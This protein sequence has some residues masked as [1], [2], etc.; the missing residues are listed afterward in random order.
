MKD[1]L[2]NLLTVLALLAAGLVLLVCVSIFVNP[3]GMLNPLPPPTMPAPLILPTATATSP[4]LPPTWTATPPLQPGSVVATLKPSSTPMPRKSQFV[5]PTF[6]ST[7][8]RTSTPTNTRTVTN[9][10]TS[11][12]TEPP[13]P[14]PTYT[15]YPTYTL[16]PTDV[17]EPTATLT[18]QP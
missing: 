1:S 12:S 5:L 14:I 3:Y 18:L 7:S 13:T 6:T 16:V 10:P 8:T 9:T 15:E 11:T 2:W 17:P 4:Q